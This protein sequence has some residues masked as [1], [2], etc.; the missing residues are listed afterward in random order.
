MPC[1]RVCRRRVDHSPCWTISAMISAQSWT[2]AAAACMPAADRASGGIQHDRLNTKFRTRYSCM[3]GAFDHTRTKFSTPPGVHA[4][5]CT[6]YRTRVPSF[7]S[8]LNHTYSWHMLCQRT[9]FRENLHSKNR[10]VTFR[11]SDIQFKM[12]KLYAT[13][14]THFVVQIKRTVLDGNEFGRIGNVPTHAST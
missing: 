4:H 3:Y 1:R 2:A 14:Q 6:C 7:Y 5:S 11:N 13:G 8:N 12:P 9:N 10:G